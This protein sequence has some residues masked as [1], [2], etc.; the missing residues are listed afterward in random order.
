MTA[1]Y[2]RLAEKAQLYASEF[3]FVEAYS[4]RGMAGKVA[5]IAFTCDVPPWSKAGKQ[6]LDGGLRYDQCGLKWIYFSPTTR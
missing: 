6:L 4:G 1:D 3:S 5:A 2:Q